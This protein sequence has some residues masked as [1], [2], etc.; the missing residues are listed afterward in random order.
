MTALRKGDILPDFTNYSWDA[1]APET[2]AASLKV[3]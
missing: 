1:S 3:K 2:V